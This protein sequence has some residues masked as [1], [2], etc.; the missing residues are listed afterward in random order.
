MSADNHLLKVLPGALEFGTSDHT[1]HILLG[2]VF[3][4][5]GVLSRIDMSG[6]SKAGARR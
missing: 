4:A 5:A 2:I 3:I 6:D 1:F